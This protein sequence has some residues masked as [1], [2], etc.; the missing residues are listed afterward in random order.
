MD[1]VKSGLKSWLFTVCRNRALDVLRKEKRTVSVDDEILQKE[2]SNV[3]SPDL[4]ADRHERLDEVHQKMV[5]LSENQQLVIRLKFEQGMSYQEISEQTGLSSS[6]VGF[7]LHNGL[8]KLREIL[9]K[10]LLN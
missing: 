3:T 6:N 10:D 8:K 9:P 7:L 5:S 1:K 2:P 4:S